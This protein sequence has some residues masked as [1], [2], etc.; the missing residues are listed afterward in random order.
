MLEQV[1]VHLPAGLP[2]WL[3]GGAVRD[4]LLRRPV[5]DFD[6]V[7]NG[8]ALAVARGLADALGGAYYPL[9]HERGVGRV[10][11]VRDDGHLTLD[12][13]R[14]RGPDLI[15]DLVAR[16]FT[17]NALATDLAQ[18]DVLIDPLG[19]ERDLRARLIRACSPTS[20][21]DDPLRV[22]R[23]VRL[24]AELRFRID[25]ST[26]AEVRAQASRLADISAERR[27]DEL[28]RCLGGPRPAAA[29]RSLDLL[30]LLP[31]LIPE[32]PALHD[33]GQSAP[34]VYDVWEHTLTVLA[35]LGD[36]LAVLDPV[37][38]AETASDLTLGLVSLRLGRHRQALGQHLAAAISGER[39]KRTLLL[40]ASLLHDS[41]KPATR[42]VEPSGRI[43]FFDHDQAGA[44]LAHDRLME[45][46]FSTD[47]A[48]H[49]SAIVAH[50]LRPLLLS[51]E[52]NVTRR[53]IYRF[54][55]Q[56]GEAG[57]DVVLLALADFLGTYGD[58]PPPVD[59]WNRLLDV[60]SQLL[61]AYFE[62]PSESIRPPALL[63]GNDVMSEFAIEAGPRLG[64]VLAALREAQAAGEVADREAARRWVSVY[65]DEHPT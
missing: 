20:L 15:A 23:A 25:P 54:G 38:D 39:P 4:A 50:H 11:L 53:A 56:C 28:V 22:L 2:A 58:G 57:I 42:S 6:F 48:Q 5:R 12:V 31:A 59:E 14:L 1:R 18:P 8:D 55:T 13:S 30:G 45:L 37:Y 36:V 46:K 27:R 21:A 10:V 34:H 43:R 60:C 52:P 32:L 62:T 35:R 3:V 40:L 24:A 33:V 51:A 47:E 16:D 9:D 17:I 7:V 49:V 44:R 63:T 19:G 65:L 64:R 61:R 29:I 41:G 26:L